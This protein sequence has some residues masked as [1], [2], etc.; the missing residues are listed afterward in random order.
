MDLLKKEI[1]KKNENSKIILN[2]LEK[3]ELFDDKFVLKLLEYILFASDC[4]DN[5]RISEV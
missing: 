2:S 1:Q 3:I 5:N 4:L